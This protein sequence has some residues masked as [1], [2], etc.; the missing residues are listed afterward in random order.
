[1]IPLI[2]KKARNSVAFDVRGL[3]QVDYV[4][5]GQALDDTAVPTLKRDLMRSLDAASDQL[6]ASGSAQRSAR[7]TPVDLQRV[8]PND[9]VV[10]PD[11]GAFGRVR[12]LTRGVNDCPL[13]IT[14]KM[15]DGSSLNYRT[16]SNNPDLP[17][18]FWLP[19]SRAR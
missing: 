15:D 14:V 17:V 8:G 10:I 5:D 9:K 16:D 13:E 7:F 1:M 19:V 6:N 4:S 18:L 3:Q 12:V 11:L 2:D